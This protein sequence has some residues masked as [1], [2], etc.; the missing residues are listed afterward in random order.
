VSAEEELAVAIGNAL[1]ERGHLGDGEMM[2][3]WHVMCEVTSF[4]PD[5][6]GETKYVNIIPGENG[7]PLHRVIGL[8][9]TCTDMLKDE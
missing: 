8:I 1:R 4:T 3:D 6:L 9:M 5:S 2:G 7:T